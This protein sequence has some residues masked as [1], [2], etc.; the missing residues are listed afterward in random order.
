[1]TKC[2]GIVRH[3]VPVRGQVS[4]YISLTRHAANTNNV[5]KVSL[6]P[7]K[8][9]RAMLNDSVR[10]EPLSKVQTLCINKLLMLHMLSFVSAFTPCQLLHL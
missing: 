3:L 1:M 10:H 7:N 8:R 4:A 2:S 6:T 9:Q 5:Y